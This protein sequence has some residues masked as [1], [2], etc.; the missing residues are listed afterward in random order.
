M[1]YRLKRHNGYLNE[2]P[3]IEFDSYRKYPYITFV[4][5]IDESYKKYIKLNF[6]IIKSIIRLHHYNH[7]NKLTEY[8]IQVV[9]DD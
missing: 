9:E 5:C 8:K 6:N 3:D 1:K 7:G 2:I 4:N